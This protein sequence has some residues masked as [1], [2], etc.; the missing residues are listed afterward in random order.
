MFSDSLLN[1]SQKSTQFSFFHAELTAFINSQS[2]SRPI[3]GELLASF[4]PKEF[5]LKISRGLPRLYKSQDPTET[6]MK[7][8]FSDLPSLRSA[9]LE[10]FLY[11]LYHDLL[12]PKITQITL[13]N[14]VIGDGWGDFIAAKE[15]IQILK[16]Q[17]PHL[18]IHW[19]ALA[20]KHLSLPKKPTEDEKNVPTI[21][22]E[23]DEKKC[24]LSKIPENAFEMLRSSDLILSLPTLYPQMNEL[25]HFLQTI[26]IKKP[27]PEVLSI[28]QYGFLESPSFNPGSARFSMGLHFLEHGIFISSPVLSPNFNQVHNKQLLD[29]LFGTSSPTDQEIE[30]YQTSH[31]FYLAYLLTEKGGAIYLHALLQ[32]ESSFDE[33]NIDICTPDIGWLVRH[34]ESQKKKGEFFLEKT[35]GLKKIEIHYQEQ[36][37]TQRLAEKGKTIRI[38]CPGSLEDHD[39]RILLALSQDFVAVRG[40]QSIS[41]AISANKIFFYDGA[42]HSRFFIKDLAALAENRI[43]RYKGA[44]L[45]FRLMKEAFLQSYMKES[46]AKW[47]DELYFQESINWQE[48]AKAMGSALQDKTTKPGFTEFNEVV[49]Q[50]YAFNSRLCQMVQRAL[51][52]HLSPEIALFEKEKKIAFEQGQISLKELLNLVKA[53]LFLKSVGSGA[54]ASIKAPR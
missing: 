23:Y 17:F 9:C 3:E 42:E 18:I 52:H 16:N 2:G 5:P 10:R 24:P 32:S 43:S 4:P 21:S 20:P 51:V 36:I 45:L 22:I 35:F 30:S 15:A 54:D 34:I 8:G 48:I 26:S 13:L 53:R 1:P 31:R 46:D 47:V 6:R 39:F 37:H 14:Y 11:P 38:L 19:I 41:Q 40:D 33:K 50:E 44:L 27:F 49:R 28:G 7:E 12:P 25:L 29:S